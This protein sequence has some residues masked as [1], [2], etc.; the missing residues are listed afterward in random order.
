[1]DT[2][3]LNG[4]LFDRDTSVRQ[5]VT[6]Q[7]DDFQ[8]TLERVPRERFIDRFMQLDNH[9][10]ADK[11]D[12]YSQL[13]KEFQIS[14]ELTEAML[15][16]FWKHYHHHCVPYPGLVDT[17][18][19]LKK[20]GFKLGLVTNGYDHVQNGTIDALGIRSFFDTVWISESAGMRKPNPKIFQ[21]GVD[22]LQVNSNEAVYVGDNPV[23]DVMGAIDAGLK[24][25]WRQQPYWDR[26]R[27]D[28]PIINEL[29]DLEDL[30]IEL[31]RTDPT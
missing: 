14:H 5:L 10:Y 13:A 30:I 22:S 6:S 29:C 8:R 16:Y 27:E 12:V 20:R 15:N 28:V 25:V 11:N 3:F 21:L 26:P 24:A 17:F 31:W 4:T 1:M 7:Y 2:G 18:N 19:G 9:L 23:A